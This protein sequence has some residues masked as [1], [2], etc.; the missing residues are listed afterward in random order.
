M[1]PEH[2]VIRHRGHRR[3][4]VQDLGGLQQRRED[5]VGTRML[6]A[7]LV[8][9]DVIDQRFLEVGVQTAGL[10][11]VHRTEDELAALLV[12]EA[13]RYRLTATSE[14]EE[15]QPTREG[16]GAEYGDA[17]W[18]RPEIS[19]GRTE[20]RALHPTPGIPCPRL[21]RHG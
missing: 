1:L 20:Q 2:R 18:S 3:G 7:D 15:V 8:L 12:A 9:D 10:L 11:L 5:E 14:L 19:I 13:H 21:D 4:D 17:D 16:I 6:G